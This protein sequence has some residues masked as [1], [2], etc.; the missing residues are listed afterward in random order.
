VSIASCTFEDQLMSQSM[1]SLSTDLFING[2]FIH[3]I[4]G[5]HLNISGS[6]FVNG[7]ASMGGAIYLSGCKSFFHHIFS[8][9]SQYIKIH[10]PRQP[11]CP[12]WRSFIPRFLQRSENCLE[13]ILPEKLRK[14]GRFRHL[15]LVRR[16]KPDPRLSLHPER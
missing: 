1:V 12:F 15:R 3:L 13:L 6:T 14:R 2:A 11:S 5:V 4:M 16:V 8:F 9:S 10:F 7:Y